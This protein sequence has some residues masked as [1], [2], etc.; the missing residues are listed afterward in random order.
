MAKIKFESEFEM[1]KYIMEYMKEDGNE[2]CQPP[3][4]VIPEYHLNEYGRCDILGI[5]K[6]N[7][8]PNG[9]DFYLQI[10]LIELKNRC[11][12]IK[13]LIQIYRYKK[14]LEIILRSFKKI[15]YSLDLTLIGTDINKGDWVY[16]ID[17]L[18]SVYIKTISMET[19]GIEFNSESD[20]KLTDFKKEDAILNFKEIIDSIKVIDEN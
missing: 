14:G 4:L 16:L 6:T 10:D 9:K 5:R 17:D 11:L 19:T 18:R 8:G 1:Q 20:Y 7:G 12:E 13:D 15:E 3:D 2:I